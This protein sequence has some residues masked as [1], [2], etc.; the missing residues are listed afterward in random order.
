MKLQEKAK[1]SVGTALSQLPIGLPGK[2]SELLDAVNLLQEPSPFPFPA[3][4]P[5]PAHSVAPVTPSTNTIS[6]ATASP[7]NG[8]MEFDFTPYLDNQYFD[9]SSY[10]DQAGAGSSVESFL[11]PQDFE[12]LFS[13]PV[14]PAL[15]PSVLMNARDMVRDYPLELLQLPGETL[16]IPLRSVV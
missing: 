10:N 6:G 11:P 16:G 14:K 3:P 1:W 15:C 5:A 9:P 2:P 12:R 8:N 7:T 13:G 4:V